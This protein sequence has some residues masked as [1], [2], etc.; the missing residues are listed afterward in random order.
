MKQLM[1]AAR[2][3]RSVDLVGIKGTG[4][5]R[6]LHD[7]TEALEREGRRVAWAATA[8]RALG[9]L[10]PV[11][12]TPDARLKIP[13]GATEWVEGRLRAALGRG[14]VVVVDDAEEMDRWSA[15]VIGRCRAAG[16]IVRA[17]V[18]APE[19]ARGEAVVRLV[20]LDAAA[21]EGLFSGPERIFRLRSDAARALWART[22]GLQAR[23]AEEVSAWL[24]SGFAR[25]DGQ[26]LTVDR[27][28]LD[29]LEAGLW[30]KAPERRRSVQSEVGRE[31]E[32][33]ARRLAR[34]GRVG[35]A[36]AALEEGLSFARRS[37]A[38]AE[39][40]AAQ[41]ERLLS[42]WVEV[43]LWEWT[44]VSLARALYEIYRAE[45]RTAAIARLE[46]LSRA[47]VAFGGG[48]DRAAALVDRVAPF[49]D[50]ELERL[51][52]WLRVA[53]ARRRSLA[54]EEAVLEDVTAWAAGA[55]DAASEARV[56]GWLGE[57]RC[58]Q[59]R[60]DEAARLQAEA[61]E[62]APWVT[63]RIAARLN[64]AAALLDGRRHREAAEWAEEARNEARACRH[65]LLEV[66]AEWILRRAAY[67]S[68]A[69][70]RPD[71]ELVEAAARTGVDELEAGVC[72][73]EAAVAL[74]AGDR[75]RAVDLAERSLGLSRSIDAQE[76]REII[77]ASSRRRIPHRTARRA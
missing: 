66:K 43:A 55:G 58:R 8:R 38:P 62:R 60:F 3:G 69:A 57:L 19:G 61:A 12:G 51:R 53:A 16:T 39:V 2:A 54:A 7:F 15:E 33:L 67:R 31:A 72:A 32:V 30:T 5:T 73:V 76:A 42:L 18:D 13:A 21:L 70:M 65:A 35:H 14:L 48:G 34:E 4:R 63:W 75:G 40:V 1:E 56:A 29:R 17:L 9:S 28:A 50:P 24:R 11:I 22:E 77:I 6:C 37:G 26:R 27:E 52:Q 47:A 71:L 25:W 49:A 74:R 20:P 41:E 64:G 59:G 45:R 44:P 23:V 10:E 36:I 46:E 68:G